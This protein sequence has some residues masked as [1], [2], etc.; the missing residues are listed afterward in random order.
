MLRRDLGHSFVGSSEEK[1]SSPEGGVRLGGEGRGG[2]AEVERSAG[3]GA[4]WTVAIL[5]LA[6]GLPVVDVDSAASSPRW[7]IGLR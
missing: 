5:G 3:G 7:T 6:C 4:G 1:R 2:V